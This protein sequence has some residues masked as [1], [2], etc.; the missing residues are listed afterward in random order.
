MIMSCRKSKDIYK[1]KVFSSMGMMNM[2]EAKDNFFSSQ[3]QFSSLESSSNSTDD[4]KYIHM[5]LYVCAHPC[6]Y[7][8]LSVQTLQMYTRYPCN[9]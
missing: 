1:D 8:Y 7:I 5:H 4:L 9:I 2:F 6:I 3:L